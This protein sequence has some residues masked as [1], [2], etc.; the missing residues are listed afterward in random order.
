MILQLNATEEEIRNGT[1]KEFFGFPCEQMPLLLDAG[2]MPMG[3]SQIMQRIVNLQFHPNEEVRQAWMNNDFLTGDAIIYH[4]YDKN[5]KKE[6][7]L[8]CP[9]L[10]KLIPGIPLKDYDGTIREEGHDYHNGWLFHGPSSSSNPSSLFE[11]GDFEEVRKYLWHPEDYERNKVWRY[12][13]KNNSELL[14]GYFDCIYQAHKSK[15]GEDNTKE[16]MISFGFSYTA[17]E[18]RRSTTGV[19]ELAGIE[20]MGM[21]SNSLCGLDFE[22]NFGDEKLFVGKRRTN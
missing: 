4:N 19:R 15:F 14:N 16:R 2:Y 11:R 18:P 13:A 21:R 9:M 10:K 20:L 22:P 8:D 7:I 17:G 1:Y 12:L 3:T 5:Y 6:I